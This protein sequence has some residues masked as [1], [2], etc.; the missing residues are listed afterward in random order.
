VP[1]VSASPVTEE[2]VVVGTLDYMSPEQVRGL[3]VDHRSDVFSFGVVLLEMLTG[4]KAFH[5]STAAETMAAILR[6]EPAE[7][8]ALAPALGQIVRHCVEKKPE[9]RFQSTKDLAFNL[10][11]VASGAIPTRPLSAPVTAAAGAPRVPLRPRPLLLAGAVLALA[12]VVA[13]IALVVGRRAP[14]G[15][16]P[17]APAGPRRIAVLPFENLGSPDQEYFADGVTD[18]IRGKLTSLASLAVIARGSSTP[19]KKTKKALQ[20]VA[21]ELDVPFLLTGTIRWERSGAGGR[22]Q[23][24]PGVAGAAE[25]NAAGKRDAEKAIALAPERPEGYLALGDYERWGQ[26]QNARA[27]ESYGHDAGRE[28]RVLRSVHPALPRLHLPRRRA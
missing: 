22:V 3:P 15:G 5:R 19:Y 20:E 17:S 7:D 18:E 6:D 14:P 26:S 12:V 1:T 24:T 8:G 21:Q 16:A 11:E 2:G 25:L 4:R 23:V 10:A 27:L 28:G 13:A 9:D